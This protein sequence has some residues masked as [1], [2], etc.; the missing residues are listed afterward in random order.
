[1]A[2]FDSLFE[3]EVLAGELGTLRAD[4]EDGGWQRRNA[5]LLHADRIDVGRR[6]VTTQSK[7]TMGRSRR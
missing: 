4:L 1:M 2:R 5:A 7:T 6:L 3:P